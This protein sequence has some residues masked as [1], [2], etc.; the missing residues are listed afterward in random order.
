MASPGTQQVA[1]AGGSPRQ[2]ELR[3]SNQSSHVAGQ[4]I[5][6]FKASAVRHAAATPLPRAATAR[7][8]ALAMPDEVV[9]PLDLLRNEAGLQ[10]MR[11]LFVTDTTAEAPRPGV[12]ALAALHGALAS[13]THSP[14]KSLTGFQLVEV[15]DKKVTPALIKRLRASN[16]IDLVEPVPNRWLRCCRSDDQPPMGAPRDQVV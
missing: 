4:L 5:V 10:S 15:K 2:V 11:P 8:A 12:M 16:A 7:V 1:S 14:R 3:K 13:S 6:R 9:G